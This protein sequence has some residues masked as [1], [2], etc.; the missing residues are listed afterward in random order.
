[1][2]ELKTVNIDHDDEQVNQEEIYNINLFRLNT[3]SKKKKDTDDFKVEVTINSSLDKVIVDTGTKVSVCEINYA[4]KWNLLTKMVSSKVRIK[5]YKSNPI[6][7]IG[8]AI[9]AVKYNSTSIVVTWHIIS[10][11]CEPILAGTAALQLNIIQF[12]HK[13]ATFHPV[14]MI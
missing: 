4:K 14:L 12:S 1:M 10:D 3:F 2:R 8:G 5:P 11:P 13:P 7:V 6:T 9:C